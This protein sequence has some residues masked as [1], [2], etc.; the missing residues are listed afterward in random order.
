MT[1][2][3]KPARWRQIMDALPKDPWQQDYVYVYPGKHNPK[4][5][6]LF[7]K[8]PDHQADTADDIGNW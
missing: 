3:P 1:A 5:Y 7:S 4:S 8:G 2:K 6:D